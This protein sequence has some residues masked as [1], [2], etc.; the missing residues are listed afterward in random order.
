MTQANHRTADYPIDELFLKRWSPRAFTEETIGEAELMTLFEAGRWAP[1]SY[2]SQPWRFIF[3]R[4][5]TSHFEKLLGLL[6]K[7]NQSWVKNAAA[8]VILISNSTMKPP[9]Q[10]KAV[11]S[12][13]HSLDA[14][15]AWVSVALQATLKGWQAHGMV[16][17]DAERAFA[18]LNVPEGFR[19]EMA[20]AI[21]RP[22][23][24]STLP[25]AFAQREAPSPRTPL[26]AL[27]ME[28]QFSES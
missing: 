15:A 10:D 6:V 8:L 28:G 2:N 12:R 4:R 19:V 3:G 14:G 16:G 23:D 17:F 7:F 18:E 25:P 22:G 13:T 5:G 11:P 24:K 26:S 27:V 9:G 1:S 21:G 20:F